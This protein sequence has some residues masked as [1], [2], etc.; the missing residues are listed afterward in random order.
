MPRKC[1]NSADSFCYVC[2]KA[3]FSTQKRSITPVIRKAY[4]CYFECKIRDQN[5]RLAPH[6]CCNTCACN[7]RNWFNQKGR[8]MPFAVPMI[9]RKPTNHVTDCYFCMVPSLQHGMSRKKEWTVN[10]PN[11]PSAIRPVPHREGLPI[12]D[13]PADYSL[14]SE[15][16]ELYHARAESPE[17]STSQD[18]DFI[19]D[20]PSADIHRI[21]QNELSDLIR[22]LDLSKNKAEIL[23]SRLQQWN[24]LQEN[25]KISVYRDRYKDLTQFFAM[26]SDLVFCHE[27]NGLMNSLNNEYKPEEW[28][29]FIDASK[30]SLKAVLLH[31]GNEL[32]YH[33]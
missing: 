30:L 18:P 1:L 5:E 17:P 14:E 31:N 16:E 15:E 13:L 28:R 24:L 2:G 22:D 20:I 32:R 10:Y 12:P 9:W 11:I 7:L 29:I 33:Q 25:V 3:T 6:I 27:I 19:P 4:H 8:S 23:A 26:K 21:T